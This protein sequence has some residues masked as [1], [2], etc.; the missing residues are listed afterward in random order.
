MLKMVSKNTSIYYK[1]KKYTNDKSLSISWSFA[2]LALVWTLSNTWLLWDCKVKHFAN[3][4]F[5]LYLAWERLA[6]L[7]FYLSWVYTTWRICTLLDTIYLPGFVLL[8][9]CIIGSWV[10]GFVFLNL[11]DKER[12]CEQLLF[13]KFVNLVS[14]LI[15]NFVL[16]H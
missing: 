13:F 2:H 9:L 4:C 16:Y 7:H 8:Q 10:H 3:I 1:W 6:Y 5:S 14:Q 15:W 12:Y 11:L